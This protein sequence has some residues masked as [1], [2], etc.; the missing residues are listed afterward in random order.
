MAIEI[1]Q[2]KKGNPLIWIIILV[3]ILGI[4]FWVVKTFLKPEEILS[5]PRMEDILPSPDSVRLNQADL[6]MSSILDNPI[7]QTLAPHISWPLPVSS[8]GHQN[9]FK[10]F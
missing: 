4:G 6:N 9:P 10:Q 5:K 1:K 2:E 3:V 8:L 7:F